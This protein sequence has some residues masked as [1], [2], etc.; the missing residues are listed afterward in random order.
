MTTTVYHLTAEGWN[1]M[2]RAADREDL[3]RRLWN[4]DE[5]VRDAGRYLRRVAT[6]D[7]ADL[8]AAFDATQNLDEAWRPE[9]PTRSTSVGDVMVDARGAW[10]VDRMGFTLVAMRG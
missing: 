2:A 10:M 8:E 4:A 5:S 6:L 7:G 9:A 1:L 3:V